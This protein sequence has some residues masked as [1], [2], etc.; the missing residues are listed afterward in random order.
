M[1]L[2]R[3]RDCSIEQSLGFLFCFNQCDRVGFGV[4][5][6]RNLYS[7]SVT[8]SGDSGE[9]EQTV[10]VCGLLSFESQVFD[11]VLRGYSVGKFKVPIEGTDGIETAFYRAVYN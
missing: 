4:V 7:V 3:K 6:E 2:N 10:L 5:F 1:I 8:R 11:I 9:L